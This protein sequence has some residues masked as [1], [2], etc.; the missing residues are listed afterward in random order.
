M[1]DLLK[2]TEE[3]LSKL[4]ELKTKLHA[5]LKAKT[6][7][8]EKV[9]KERDELKA[10]IARLLT[11]NETLRKS[12]GLTKLPTMEKKADQKAEDLIAELEKSISKPDELLAELGRAPTK[13]TEGTL[14]VDQLLQQVKTGM[15]KLGQQNFSIEQ[16]VDQLLE[17]LESPGAAISLHKT[18]TSVKASP[19]PTQEKSSRTLSAPKVSLSA[20][21][22]QESSSESESSL[23][24]P[25]E[26][27]AKKAE[28]APSVHGIA[29]IAYPADGVIVCPHCGEQN[30]AQIDNKAKIIAFAPVKKFAKKYYCKSCRSEW[31]YNV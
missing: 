23:R 15:F 10:E 22:T 13:P 16:K 20:D 24:K 1:E 31:D 3:E 6:E 7:E 29:S 25:S 26:A 19:E 5:Q 28:S 14:T 21:N 17:R 8:L 18:P 27:I 11:E 2:T 4:N 30:F 12:P 9:S